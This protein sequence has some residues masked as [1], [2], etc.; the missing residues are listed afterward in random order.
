[1]NVVKSSKKR[2]MYACFL[3]GSTNWS[4]ENS[5]SAMHALNRGEMGMMWSLGLWIFMEDLQLPRHFDCLC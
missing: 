5:F 2:E 1:M 4:L 3:W